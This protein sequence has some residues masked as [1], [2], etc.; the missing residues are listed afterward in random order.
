[1]S[2]ESFPLALTL[3]VILDML[4][5][6]PL[7]LPHPVR[8]MGKAIERLEPRFR[9]LALTPVVS[10]GLMAALLVVGVW[11]ISLL[12]VSLAGLVHPAVGVIVQAAML[13]TCI[14]ARSLA[15]AARTVGQAL[16]QSGLSA[17]RRAVAMI[18]G[19][20]VDRLDETGVTR[21]AVE[22]VA[23]NLVDGVVSPLFF[24]LLG[25][26]PLAMAYKMVNTLDS[27]V[28]YKNDRYREFGRFAARMDDVAN[29]IPARLSVPF[30]ALAAHL[31]TGRAGRT[32][33]TALADG[34]AHASPNAGY[35]EAA[36][37]GALGMWMGGPNIYHGQRVEKPVIGRRLGAARAHHIDQACQLMLATSLLVFMA[38]AVIGLAFQM[39][40]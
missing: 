31:V 27:M 1:M 5:G 36:F 33:K 15:E 37:A 13:Y 24:A 19:R 30:I 39:A 22:T 32:F 21:A 11:L 4:L 9:S 6:D 3:A 29:F 35:P 26:A 2:A 16:A 7:W 12:V 28:G 38:A 34:R 25:G 17:G 14:S 20:E 40:G 10:G 18:V 23:E 8:W